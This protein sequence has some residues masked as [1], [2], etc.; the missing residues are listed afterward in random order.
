[1]TLSAV[2]SIV[3]ELMD[4]VQGLDSLDSVSDGGRLCCELASFI[5]H[6]EIQF[7]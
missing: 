5:S 2:D 6:L 4:S 1:M 3:S 7:M